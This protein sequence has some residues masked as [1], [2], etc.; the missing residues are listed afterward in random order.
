MTEQSEEQKNPYPGCIYFIM[1]AI[2]GYA[3]VQMSM[4]RLPRLG[5]EAW[6]TTTGRVLATS[7][8][9][10]EKE[11][12]TSY[13][14]V[15]NYEYEVG[16]QSFT[17]EATWQDLDSYPSQYLAERVLWAYPTGGAITVYYNPREP[18]RSVLVPGIHDLLG[19]MA[20]IAG[21]LILGGMFVWVTLRWLGQRWSE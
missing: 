11:G 4:T 18:S 3:L 8:N 14:P 21:E 6:P 20:M 16:G 2:F 1:A 10:F 19:Y 12:G 15:V 9:P 17:G 5:S 13:Q 7:V